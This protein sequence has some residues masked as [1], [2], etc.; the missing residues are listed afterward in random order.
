MISRTCGLLRRCDLLVVSPTTTRPS[1]RRLRLGALRDAETIFWRFSFAS[2][3]AASS[4]C[5]PPWRR[6]VE[7]AVCAI[8][9]CRGYLRLAD[10]ARMHSFSACRRLG[11]V[12]GSMIGFTMNSF[13]G[14]PE[15]PA[16]RRLPQP[17]A[18]GPSCWRSDARTARVWLS[19]SSDLQQ[20][21]LG[22]GLGVAAPAPTTKCRGRDVHHRGAS[23]TLFERLFGAMGSACRGVLAR[24][25][26]R[27]VVGER[28]LHPP[29]AVDAGLSERAPVKL[30]NPHAVLRVEEHAH[31]DLVRAPGASA[32]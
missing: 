11:S 6:Y 29:R 15:N 5:A 23:S 1:I 20:P 30:S 12:N 27:R 3:L 22:E 9:R 4:C 19:R 13:P 14:G 28:A 2:L 10:L 26:A 21:A 32:Q 18:S 17:G 31:E 24:N 7:R 25:H 16:T 8:P